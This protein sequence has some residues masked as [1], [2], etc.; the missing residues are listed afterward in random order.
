MK[1]NIKEYYDILKRVNGD[2]RFIVIPKTDPNFALYEELWEAEL[3][4]AGKDSKRP[5]GTTPDKGDAVLHTFSPTIKGIQ[6]QSQL[7]NDLWFSKFRAFIWGILISAIIS[8]LLYSVNRVVY[9][10]F[11]KPFFNQNTN[12]QSQRATDTATQ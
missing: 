4:A 5:N 6:L 12:P 10:N 11:I 3:I 9:G 7:K 1:R 8:T 2:E